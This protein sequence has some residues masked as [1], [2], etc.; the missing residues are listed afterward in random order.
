VKHEHGKALTMSDRIA[1]FNDGRIEQIGTPEELRERPATRF[2]AAFIG[3]TNF[4]PGTVAG[5]TNLQP[6]SSWNATHAT[7]FPA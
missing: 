7:A 3:E 2:V 6:S 4:F 5:A 1:V